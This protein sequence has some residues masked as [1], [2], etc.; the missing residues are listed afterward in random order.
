MP[1]RL[2]NAAS[3]IRIW[4]IFLWALVCTSPQAASAVVTTQSSAD[5][6][7]LSLAGS[8]RFRL[9]PHN[10][11]IDARWF[12]TTLP[13]SI[14]LPGSC[15]QNGFGTPTTRPSIGRLTPAVRFDGTA[16]YQRDVTIPDSWHDKR[17]ELFLERCLWKSRAWLD[18]RALGEQDSLST[19]HRYDLGAV[20]VGRHVLTVCVDNRY[21]FRIGTWAHAITD[22]TQGRW[23]GLIGKLELRA[24][25]SVWIHD[26]QAYP[27]VAGARVILRGKIGTLAHQPGDGV[28]QTRLS[29]STPDV[30]SPVEHTTAVHWT[31]DGGAFELAIPMADAGEPVQLWSEFNPRG[32]RIEAKLAGGTSTAAIQF[33]FRNLSTGN[34]QI[35]NN[36]R[37]ILLRGAVDECVYPLT[38][39][40]PMDK[41]AWSRTLGIC[42]S[43][44]LNYMRF[45]SWCPPEAAYEAA[46]ELGFIFQVEVPLW[47]MGA[48]PFGELPPRDQYIRNELSRI[49]DEYG[50]HPSFGLMAMGNESRGD[51]QS[52]VRLG[53][54]LDGRHLYRCEGDRDSR[55]GDYVEGG[56]RGIYGPRTDWDRWS[57]SGG[58]IAGG[59]PAVPDSRFID[60]WVLHETGQWGMYPNF[61]QIKK[62]TGLMKP[63][64]FIAYRKSLAAHGMLDE[65]APFSRASGALSVL[66][67]KEEIEASLRTWPLGGF[68]ILEARDY[69]GQGTALVGW[70]DS[71][72]ESKG[73][74][75]PQQFRCFCGPTVCL[76][77]MPHRVWTTADIFEA[78]AQVSNYGPAAP[79][80]AV[81]WSLSASDGLLLSRGTL[82][83]RVFDSG[84]VSLAGMIRVPLAGTAAPTRATVRLWLDR[85]PSIANSWNIWVYPAELPP[86]PAPVH[87]FVI[88]HEFE[89]A[90]Q[91]SLSDGG[92]VLLF[93][94]PKN[95]RNALPGS[96]TPVFWDARLFKQ[97]GTMGILCDPHH[98]A[99]ADF[100][101]EEH[102][103]WQWA[104]LLGRFSAADS[105]R[106]AGAPPSIYEKMN[107]IAHDVSGRSKAIIL[108]D[109]PPDFRPIV[110]VIDN[111][112]RNHKLGAI[113]E[114]AVGPGRLL[115]CA[116]DLE[117]DQQNRPAARQLYRSLCRYVGGNQFNPPVSLSPSE[118]AT[119]LK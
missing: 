104:D 109:T 29:P 100:P 99:L 37:A 87:P 111:Y 84:R 58:W 35:T 19:P 67:Y 26:L 46:D 83:S 101:T 94:S 21:L 7:V 13:Q 11:G 43:Y 63:E 22:D 102:S 51:L 119:M 112:D 98:P 76:L 91:S 24:T 106:V 61:D 70:L 108:D 55:Q 118:M 72:W 38:G 14:Q 79:T 62:Y 4:P 92:R 56:G 45:H 2:W 115:V 36:G 42:Q 40:P 49:L 103:D 65:D 28:V 60:P 59:S 1:E 82:P 66:L 44:G 54:A 9:D 17:V 16:W 86:E 89:T 116:L 6:S 47:T 90:A 93:A 50:N 57:T 30:H 20:S 5:Q 10:Q 27:D 105:F 88:A 64:N 31:A 97:T 78:Q 12:D 114:A 73:L 107:G 75:T 113:F 3:L 117:T 33:G 71:F 48:P 53:R 41:A 110:Q 34:G 81:D 68:Q 77:R 18:G 52:L 15:E 39:Y 23:N 74:I 25:D 80:S 95:L 8:W 69:P 96:F 32:Y 85:Q